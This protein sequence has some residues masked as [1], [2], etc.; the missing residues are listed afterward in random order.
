VETLNNLESL[1]SIRGKINSNFASIDALIAS[2]LKD[3]YGIL[4]ILPACHAHLKSA[5][6][7]IALTSS[8]SKLNLNTTDFMIDA[9]GGFT[10]DGTNKRFIW[11][12]ADTYSMG[13]FAEF[14]GSAGLQ[15]TSGLGGGVTVTLGLFIDG[16]LILETPLNFTTLSR[17]KAYCANDILVDDTT[18]LP[19]LTQ[20]SYVEI[21][22]KAGTG[23]TP[24]MTLDFFNITVRNR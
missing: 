16:N 6:T 24:T 7:G 20:A 22:A 5:L 4:P 8:W 17:I 13:I 9:L 15:I 10:F 14:L 21:F 19:L 18:K 1:G 2:K 3:E 23:E 11:D 12:S